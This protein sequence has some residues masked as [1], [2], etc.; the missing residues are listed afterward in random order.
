MEEGLIKSK[1]SLLLIILLALSLCLGA[2][3][4]VGLGATT[5]LTVPDVM[6]QAGA[7]VQVPVNL[8]SGGEAAGVQF[9]IVYNG[10]LLEFQSAAEGS[11][12]SGFTVAANQVAA[13]KARVIVYKSGGGPIPAGVGSAAVITFK[14]SAG[15]QPGN[16]CPLDLDGVLISDAA[17]NKIQS[18]QTGGFFRVP[19][20]GLSAPQVE[21]RAGAPVQ[22][23]VRFTGNGQACGIQFDLIYCN[24]LLTYQGFAPGRLPAG[25]TVEANQLADNKVRVIIYNGSGMTI[26]E[27]TETVAVLSFQV[28]A[29]AQPGQT[30][31]L[32]LGGA[33]ISDKNANQVQVDSTDGLFRVSSLS[34]A[35]P[36]TEGGA[37]AIVQVPVNIT[38]DGQSGGVQFDLVFCGQLL[39]YQSVAP[40]SLPAGFTVDANQLAPDRVRVITHKNGAITIPGGTYS[41]AVL[42]FQVSGSA[43]PGQTCQL[44]LSNAVVSDAAGNSIQSVELTGGLFTVHGNIQLNVSPESLLLAVHGQRQISVTTVPPGATLAFSSNNTTV[45]GVDG[46]GKITGA[47]RGTAVVTV[48]ASQSGYTPA[49][50]DISV[51]VGIKGDV[52][53][54]GYVNVLDV[55]RAVDIALGEDPPPAEL[56]LF[57]ADMDDNGSIDVV[58]VVAIINVALEE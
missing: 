23:P 36:G 13:N 32:D 45:A 27:G 17:G 30:C 7:F 35:V 55:V 49:S 46:S 11:L 42:S 39:T 16:S 58:D 10:Q 19:A 31:L 54:D 29:G 57:A 40:G 4:A 6:G 2:V 25:F 37:G 41:V 51:T 28:S 34:L 47:G 48:T 22:I 1:K 12:T 43:Q 5:A 8:T 33:V 21:G 14:V 24:P 9:D 53:N 20:L 15:A 52:N 44:E 3:P 56:E 50:K 26:P 18:S 38:S